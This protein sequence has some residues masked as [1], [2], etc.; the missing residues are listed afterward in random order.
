MSNQSKT[1]TLPYASLKIKNKK[2]IKKKER[3]MS[4]DSS[5]PWLLGVV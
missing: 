4:G 5:H 2:K 1:I 3:K